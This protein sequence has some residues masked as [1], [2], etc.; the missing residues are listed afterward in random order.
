[1]STSIWSMQDTTRWLKRIGTVLPRGSRNGGR[2][3]Q[4]DTS[5]S[6]EPVEGYV[7]A[8]FQSLA[9]YRF[10]SYAM[11][12]GL[13]FGLNP[14]EQPS[15]PLVGVVVLVGLYNIFR[16]ARR[17][18]P[19]G[20]GT[21]AQWVTLGIDVA[22]SVT[23]ILASN[24][25]DSPF[26]MYSL[27]PIL[28]ASLLM[29]ARSAV[30]VAGI[31]LG[32]VSGPHIAAGL[33]ITDYPWLLSGNYLAFSLLFSSVCLLIAYLPFLANLKWHLRVREESLASERQ[34]LR[35]EVHDNVAQTLAFLSLKM[36]RA[37]ERASSPSN[38]LTSADV[39]DISSAVE[40]AYLAVRDYLDGTQDSE[41]DPPLSTGLSNMIDQWKRDTAMSAEVSVTGQEQELPTRVKYQLLQI[42]RE[43]LANVAKHA[44]T[45][46]AWVYLDSTPQA[47][48]LRV[49]DGGRGF[50]TSSNRGHGTD[51]MQ[52]RA[53]LVGAA[54]TIDS[55]I[56]RGTEVTIAYPIGTNRRNS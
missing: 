25:L 5:P 10:T 31:F 22:L 2:A 27:S 38:V 55:A 9:V 21:A 17:F 26:L 11:G 45:Q 1:M 20:Q 19:T 47:V 53:T 4:R 14:S 15:T 56:G 24:G 43:A 50:A 54:V 8:I 49:K 3:A 48:T 36:R 37:E 40:R 52:E 41:I 46:L 6:G 29:D 34:R 35:R 39:K 32:A 30:A 18:D 23:L 33:E 28:T 42:A 12:V 51:I 7:K 16:V 13:I 44:N